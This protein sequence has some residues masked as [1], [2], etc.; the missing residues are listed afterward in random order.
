MNSANSNFNMVDKNISSANILQ[1]ATLPIYDASYLSSEPVI[2]SELSSGDIL[3]YNGSSWTNISIPTLVG[4]TGPEGI[5][6]IEGPPGPVAY[7]IGYTGPSGVEGPQGQPGVDGQVG[8]QGIA[9]TTNNSFHYTINFT[10][11]VFPPPGRITSSN[12][13]SPANS[14]MYISS[15]TADN[16]DIGSLYLLQANEGS[17]IIIQ[18]RNDR[19]IQISYNLLLSQKTP[20]STFVEYNLEYINNN[21]VFFDGDDVILFISFI[22]DVGPTGLTG[23]TGPTGPTGPTGLTGPT[24]NTGPTGATGNTGPTGNTAD[25]PADWKW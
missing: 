3:V 8:P 12:D 7:L 16:I 15:S 19:T 21:G 5:P 4:P 9:G 17:N 11:D 6:G 24:G 25:Q 20:V 10:P 14:T 18:N 2:Y 13:F 1:F 22:G 23:L